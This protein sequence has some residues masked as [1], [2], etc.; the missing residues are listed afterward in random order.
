MTIEPNLKCTADHFILVDILRSQR[1]SK[2]LYKHPDYML[3]D[4]NYKEHIDTAIRE[5]LI[6]HSNYAEEYYQAPPH[7][8]LHTTLQGV[9]SLMRQYMDYSTKLIN[10]KIDNF[11]RSLDVDDGELLPEPKSI[12]YI[13]DEII[14]EEND[15]TNL[16][17]ALMKHIESAA[18]SFR[19]KMRNTLPNKISELKL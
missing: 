5:F 4:R 16:F 14:D 3:D 7:H 13:L 15:P 11:M 2:S 9:S 8:S 17:F 19:K 1:A 12:N 6:L 18:C 10:A